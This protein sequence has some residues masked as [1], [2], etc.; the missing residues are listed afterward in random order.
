MPS[1]DSSKCPSNF[2]RQPEEPDHGQGYA[3]RMAA[4]LTIEVLAASPPL[5][6]ALAPMTPMYVRD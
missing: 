1:N 2:D 4:A 3:E 5:I 6:P